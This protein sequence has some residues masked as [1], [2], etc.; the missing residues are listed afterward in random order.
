MDNISYILNWN[1]NGLRTHFNDIKLLINNFNPI[2]F[3]LQETNIL[4]PDPNDLDHE[5]KVKES[6]FL[7]F[8]GYEGYH[9]YA[10]NENGTAHGGASIWVRNG[11]PHK[12]LTID[13]QLQTASVQIDIQRKIT[14]SSIYINNKTTPTL[15]ILNDFKKQLLFIIG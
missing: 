1:C 2:I 4:A 13:T 5:G 12:P 10:T 8:K 14:I 15:E 7:K 6:P 3:S 9:S 11:V